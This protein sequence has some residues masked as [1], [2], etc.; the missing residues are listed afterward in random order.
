MNDGR[1]DR[2]RE[3]GPGGP[4]RIVLELQRTGAAVA[5][6]VDLP[7]GARIR[8][9]LRSIDLR[10]EGVAVF[11]AGTL[12]SLD[13]AVVPNERLVVVSTFSGG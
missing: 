2:E 4:T 5:R 8:D 12:V 10:P 1:P 9:A 6:V 13:E 7:A 3:P 11:R